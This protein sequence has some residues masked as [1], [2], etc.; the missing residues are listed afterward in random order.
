VSRAAVCDSSCLI[1]LERIGRLALLQASFAPLIAPPQVVEEC[2]GVP[3]WLE[4]RRVQNEPF[5]AA[6]GLNLHIG[7][8]AAIALVAEVSG[9]LVVLDDRKARSIARRLHQDV[10]GTIGVV[11]RC[12]RLGVLEF[13]RPVLDELDAAG[14]RV[15][16]ALRART[17]ELAGELAP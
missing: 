3:D 15:A 12:K 6:L 9:A 13:V 7:E 11:L 14:F 5:L 4:V 16:P 1:A 10:I 8:A 2:G 17:L